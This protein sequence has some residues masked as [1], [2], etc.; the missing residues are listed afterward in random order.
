MTGFVKTDNGWERVLE[1]VSDSDGF[2]AD[3]SVTG[4]KRWRGGNQ[5]SGRSCEGASRQGGH[6][7]NAQFCTILHNGICIVLHDYATPNVT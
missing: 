3:I 2:N 6:Y 4:R 1:I 5:E 7:A